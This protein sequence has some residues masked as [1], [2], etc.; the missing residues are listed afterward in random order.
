MNQD[1]QTKMRYEKLVNE[2][3]GNLET[4]QFEV[5]RFECRF[6]LSCSLNKFFGQK[7]LRAVNNN[8][9][10]PSVYHATIEDPLSS[11]PFQ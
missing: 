8:G 7:N 9:N 4:P 10:A 11:E 1:T 6:I 2:K 3:I 5:S